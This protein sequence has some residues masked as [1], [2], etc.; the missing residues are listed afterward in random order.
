VNKRKD[1]L[2]GF[3]KSGGF[4]Q[5]SEKSK[6]LKGKFSEMTKEWGILAGFLLKLSI[7]RRFLTNYRFLTFFRVFLN[8]FGVFNGFI[9]KKRVGDF[10]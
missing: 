1:N 3:K 5:V 2:L 4:S 9:E 10:R 8:V 7:F 6:I